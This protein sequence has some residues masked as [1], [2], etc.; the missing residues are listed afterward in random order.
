MLSPS[1]A[2]T[3]H[4]AGRFPLPI[5]AGPVSCPATPVPENDA[6]VRPKFLLLSRAPSSCGFMAEPV[7]TH[8]G[9]SLTLHKRA[10]VRAP[11]T[12]PAS[13]LPAAQDMKRG[14]STKE[15]WLSAKGEQPSFT[16]DS[17]ESP[18]FFE[19]V[20]MRQTG[21]LRGGRSHRHRNEKPMHPNHP[22]RCESFRRRGFPTGFAQE[23][24][25]R[26]RPCTQH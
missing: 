3:A 1:H 9:C 5:Q 17:L 11:L 12:E 13:P 18:A 2:A 6:E 4:S 21:M 16:E 19:P 25:D 7:G 26:R 8:Q 15:I 24:T 23:Q 14:H 10:D 22:Q 20:G